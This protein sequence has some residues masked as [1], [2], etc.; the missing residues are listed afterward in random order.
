MRGR[1]STNHN[2]IGSYSSCF[3]PVIHAAYYLLLWLSGVTSFADD[4]DIA[5]L[6]SHLL[7]ENSAKVSVIVALEQV[8]CVLG[9]NCMNL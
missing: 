1:T 8:M 9:D 3:S 7:S 4:T 6:K 5:A 2:R